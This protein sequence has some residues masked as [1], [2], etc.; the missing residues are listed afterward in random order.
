MTREDVERWVQAYRR[1]WETNNAQDVASLFS[2]DAQ[3]FTEPFAQPW[4]G[5]DTIVGNWL[6]RKDEPGT[7]TFSFEVLAVDGDLGVVRGETEYRDPPRRYANLWL[8]RLQPDGR[9]S[10]FTEYWVK[11]RE[12]G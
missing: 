3:Y 2:D 5:R 1:A 7:T 9:A 11:H 10:L 6:E 4:E 8:V 12:P